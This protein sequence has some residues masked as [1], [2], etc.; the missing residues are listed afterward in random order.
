MDIRKQLD[1]LIR[2]EM[3]ISH[4]EDLSAQSNRVVEMLTEYQSALKDFIK[5]EPSGRGAGRERESQKDAKNILDVLEKLDW[6]LMLDRTS[7]NLQN[8]HRR[9]MEDRGR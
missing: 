3:K 6:G 4:S 1:E 5:K 7:S 8:L 2:K 9:E